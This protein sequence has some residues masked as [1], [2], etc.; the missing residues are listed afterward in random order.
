MLTSTL[1]PGCAPQGT[2]S[3]PVTS[4]TIGEGAAVAALD[5][6]IDRVVSGG[7][8]CDERGEGFFR[9][10]AYGGGFEAVYHHLYVQLLRVDADAHTVAVVA[11]VPVE[12][13]QDA[14]TVVTDLTLAGAPDR[15]CGDGIVTARVVRR[16][17]EGEIVQR[18][19]LRIDAVGHYR[20]SFAPP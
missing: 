17:G 16:A 14:G 20:A 6:H 3:V 8:W 13:T 19:R 18:M 9:V 5:V 12:E 11:S 10:V 2:R 1:L 4:Q 7:R 15:A